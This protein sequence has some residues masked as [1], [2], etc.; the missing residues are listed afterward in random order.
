[1]RRKERLHNPNQV[2]SIY[3]CFIVTHSSSI[4]LFIDRLASNQNKPSFPQFCLHSVLY[5]P[6]F[7]HNSAS[8]HPSCIHT[9]FTEGILKL[10]HFRAKA[11]SSFSSFLQPL[12]FFLLTVIS[13]IF[14]SATVTQPVDDLSMLTWYC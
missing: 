3:N 8:P 13:T 11:L 4:Y 9:I 2:E 10:S 14:K 1:M 5:S 6:S 7:I 12:S